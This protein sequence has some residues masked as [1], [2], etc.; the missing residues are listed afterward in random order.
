MVLDVNEI[1]VQAET[2]VRRDVPLP[3][4]DSLVID[5]KNVLFAHAAANT[6][7]AVAS[8]VLSLAHNISRLGVAPHKVHLCWEASANFRHAL[9]PEYKAHRPTD[10]SV[11]DSLIESCRRIINHTAITQWDGVGGEGDDV[12]ATVAQQQC[13]RVAIW[14]TDGDM[15]QLVD[16]NTIIFQPYAEFDPIAYRRYDVIIDA[17]K[18]EAKTG[19]PP[20]LITLQKAM[21]GDAGDGVPGVPGLGK[22]RSAALAAR[23][24][25]R[26][27]IVD[28]ATA[29]LTRYETAHKKE[30]PAIAADVGMT[31]AIATSIVTNAD[32]LALALDL[33]TMRS[34]TV[35]PRVGTCDHDGLVAE[36]KDMSAYAM[37]TTTVFAL[38][39]N[40]E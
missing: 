26:A 9:L 39:M 23:Y 21:N 37:L 4:I 18:V 24:Q 34:I 13:G 12:V 3:A 22:K 40:E 5:G 2:M 20:R 38:A 10:T 17:A 19:V 29:A 6:N 27:T 31:R 28:A 33:V 11:I 14:S 8:F 25:S 7:E 16:D 35:I 15:M 36:I 1:K 30:H 32:V